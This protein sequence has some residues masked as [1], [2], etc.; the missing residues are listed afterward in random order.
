MRRRDFISALAGVA[1]PWPSTIFAQGIGGRRIA[2]LI[3]TSESDSSGQSYVKALRRGLRDLHW[4]EDRN[5]AI[6]TYWTNGDLQRTRMLAVKLVESQPDV[7]IAHAGL[8]TLRQQTR[9][10]PIVFVLVPDPVGSRF[11]VSLA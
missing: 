8:R 10:I 5:I 9:N 7:I 2:V 11:V 4:V 1:A 3:G 6:D